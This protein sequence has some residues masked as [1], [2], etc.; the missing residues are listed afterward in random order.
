MKFIY[1]FSL[2][3]ILSVCQLSAQDVAEKESKKDSS[4]K[5]VEKVAEKRP[6][7]YP[8]DVTIGGQKAV[9]QKGNILF[10]VIEKPVKADALLEIE[11]AAPMLIVNAFA[12]K[13]NGAV[14]EPG[15][16]PAVYFVKEKNAVKLTETMD[17]KPLK[18]GRY[19]VNVVANGTTSRVVFEV[20]GA[21]GAKKNLKV[22]SVKQV[23]DFLTK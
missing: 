11:K 17:K 14:M 5:V 21:E 8:F 22:P 15:A 13:E 20:E 2:L 16:Q 3:A 1:H 4:E 7:L 23:Y 19:L 10:A 6:M 18:P 12:V 9:M